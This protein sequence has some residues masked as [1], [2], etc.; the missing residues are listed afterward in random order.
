M[1]C[2]SATGIKA[3]P[4]PARGEGKGGGRTAVDPVALF[5]ALDG[6]WEE[7]HVD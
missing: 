7:E 6:G 2:G 3:F 1:I 4:S 5:K